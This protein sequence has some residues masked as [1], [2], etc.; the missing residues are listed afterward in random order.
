MVLYLVV[1]DLEVSFKPLVGLT[2]Y[3]IHHAAVPH[4]SSFNLLG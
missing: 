3:V 1:N 4:S 2:W